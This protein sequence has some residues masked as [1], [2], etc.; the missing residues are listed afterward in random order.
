MIFLSCVCC[1]FVRVCLCVPCGRLLGGWPFGSCL[2]CL[3]VG[4]LRS[5]DNGNGRERIQKHAKNVY[6]VVKVVSVMMKVVAEG[7]RRV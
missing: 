5:T 7:A 6:P 4:L 2:W 1:A 3:A